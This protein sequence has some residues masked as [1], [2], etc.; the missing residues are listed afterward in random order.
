MTDETVWDFTEG[1]EYPSTEVEIRSVEETIPAS[2]VEAEQDMFRDTVK[3]RGMMNIGPRVKMGSLRFH[4]IGGT[5][6]T[7]E[8]IDADAE[9]AEGTPLQPADSQSTEDGTH[10]LTNR[11]VAGSITE[12]EVAWKSGTSTGSGLELGIGVG[13]L[14]QTTDTSI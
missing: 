7:V 11:D 10:V 6:T 13:L 3:D 1:M 9:E 4:R 14:R 2:I 8:D 12:S 5:V